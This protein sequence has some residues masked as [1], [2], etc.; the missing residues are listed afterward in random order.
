MENKNHTCCNLGTKTQKSKFDAMLKS[1]KK[2]NWSIVKILSEIQKIYGYLPKGV[3]SAYAKNTNTALS[4]IYGVATFYTQ[5]SLEPKGK[6]V[7]SVCIGTACYVN[8][9]ELVLEKFCHALGIQ[10]GEYTE[11]GLFSIDET[12]CIG[13]CGIAPV[14]MVNEDV[15]RTVKVSE[16]EGIIKH[17]R[18]L[19]NAKDK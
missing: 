11:D 2:H 4:D 14:V 16:V 3:L 18:E 9:A 17:Y 1:A 8:G 12:R 7:I 10:P 19:E 6:Y 15:H 13:T 5:F